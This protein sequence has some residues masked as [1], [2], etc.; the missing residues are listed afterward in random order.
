MTAELKQK[1]EEREAF[2]KQILDFVNSFVLKHGRVTE[3][4]EGSSS[5]KVVREL[6][7]FNG[8]SFEW[9]LGHHNNRI[10]ISKYSY[11]SQFM[12]GYYSDVF[13]MVYW[14]DVKNCL[15]NRFLADSDWPKELLETMSNAEAILAKQ[16]ADKQRA[17]AD[18]EEI[19]RQR[20]ELIPLQERARKLKLL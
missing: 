16:I 15:V 11:D 18:A 14:Q 12:K 6:R 19:K 20:D 5:T 1:I 13:S 7:N 3:R 17:Q 8:F 9:C 4:D 10:E 2:L